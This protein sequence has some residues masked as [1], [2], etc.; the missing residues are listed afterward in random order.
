M[1][2]QGIPLPRLLNGVQQ[3]PPV[4]VILLLLGGWYVTRNGGV[5]TPLEL[6]LYPKN[7][8]Y[9]GLRWSH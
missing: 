8:V 6:Y 2:S 7:D 1:E 9:I 5:F 4:T 3:L